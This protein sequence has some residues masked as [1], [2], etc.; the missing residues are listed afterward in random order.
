MSTKVMWMGIE[1]K[2]IIKKNNT[3]KNIIV[4]FKHIKMIY[5]SFNSIPIILRNFQFYFTGK[6]IRSKEQHRW[7][8]SVLFS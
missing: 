1:N 3:K 5:T 7:N 4:F 6:V 2:V 8:H